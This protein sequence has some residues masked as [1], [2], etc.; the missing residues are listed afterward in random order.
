M[1][2][3]AGSECGFYYE[4]LHRG[5]EHRECRAITAPGSLAWRASDCERCPVPEILHRA[6]S[7]DLGVRVKIRALPFGLARTVHVQCWCDRHVLDIAD[8]LK[9]CPACRAEAEEVFRAAMDG[10][11]PVS[12]DPDDPLSD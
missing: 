12:A 5:A 4:D 6:G 2:T 11:A 3:P 8:P 7:P 9:G 1:R 10:V